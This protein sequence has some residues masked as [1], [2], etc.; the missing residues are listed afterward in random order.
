M[1]AGSV[2]VRRNGVEPVGRVLIGRNGVRSLSRGWGAGRFA[3][4][5]FGAA[6]A[7]PSCGRG[8]RSDRR[9]IAIAIAA[10]STARPASWPPISFGSSGTV[11]ESAAAR[12]RA[13][14]VADGKPMPVEPGLGET[15][16]N[17]PPVPPVPPT[18]TPGYGG[19]VAG[20]IV[21][22]S[23]GMLTDVVGVADVTSTEP[24]AW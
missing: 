19:S 1:R 4:Q 8:R 3:Y 21:T 12:A 14:L 9:A 5:F 7:G 15:V 22:V 16:G 10:T 2:L 23:G 13:D 17:S 6:D 24:D 11:E 18:P 20:G